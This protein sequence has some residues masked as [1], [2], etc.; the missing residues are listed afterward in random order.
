MYGNAI[1]TT[2]FF[3]GSVDKV[4]FSN[5]TTYLISGDQRVALGDI[6]EVGAVDNI[7]ENQ[8]GAE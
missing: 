8:T 5:N 2:T 4:T 6:V 3:T 7:T 1:Q